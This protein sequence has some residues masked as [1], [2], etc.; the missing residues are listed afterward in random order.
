M[1]N[2]NYI[3]E[4][5]GQYEDYPY[6]FRDPE[7]ERKGLGETFLDGLDKIN[8]YCFGGEKDRVPAHAQQLDGHWIH[9]A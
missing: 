3:K 7:D 1:H 6:P 2:P 4:V 5:R 8:H 9:F